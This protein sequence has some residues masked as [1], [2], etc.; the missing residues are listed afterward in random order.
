[1]RSSVEKTLVIM[2][3]FDESSAWFFGNP[4][5]FF[6]VP[7]HLHINGKIELRAKHFNWW[8]FEVG[9]VFVIVPI[10]KIRLQNSFEEGL[11]K[12]S[13]CGSKVLWMS[14]SK[15]IQKNYFK[16]QDFVRSLNK[17][18]FNIFSNSVLTAR[19]ETFPIQSNKIPLKC[20]F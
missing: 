10:C 5:L 18:N 11:L 7:I 3:N 15:I 17:F 8:H 14:K 20:T 6:F 19:C 9:K 13:S 12:M 2:F 1:M 4:S 16:A